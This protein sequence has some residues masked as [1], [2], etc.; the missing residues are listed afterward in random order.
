MSAERCVMIKHNFAYETK[1]VEVRIIIVSG[2]LWS[3]AIILSSAKVLFTTEL[4]KTIIRVSETLL[5]IVLVYFNMSIAH[6]YV[7]IASNRPSNQVSLK[8]KAGKRY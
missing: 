4:F 6:A 1:V 3:V 8:A 7:S 2:L 5:A